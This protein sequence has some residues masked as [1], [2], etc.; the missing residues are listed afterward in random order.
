MSV[1]PEKMEGKYYDMSARDSKEETGQHF[2]MSA[3]D[4]EESGRIKHAEHKQTEKGI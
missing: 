3:N 2:K 4:G 1:E